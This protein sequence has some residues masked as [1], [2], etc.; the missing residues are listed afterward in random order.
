MPFLCRSILVLF[1]FPDEVPNNLHLLAAVPTGFI[2]SMDDDFLHKLVDDGERQF[3]Y[4]H[5][6]AYNGGEV[7]KVGFVLFVAVDRRLLGLYK[8]CQFFL[9]RLILEG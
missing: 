6:L 1:Q 3:S 5:I 9:L 7:V 4:S 2:G 8:L